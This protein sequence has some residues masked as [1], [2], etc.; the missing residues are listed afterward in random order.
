MREK[1]VFLRFLGR[2]KLICTELTL[3][4]VVLQLGCLTA[5][6]QTLWALIYQGPFKDEIVG[7]SAVSKQSGRGA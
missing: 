5:P 6:S 1:P 2:N 7:I 4:K 3:K